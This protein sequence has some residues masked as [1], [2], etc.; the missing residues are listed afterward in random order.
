VGYGINVI[1]QSRRDGQG[2]FED[3]MVR[4]DRVELFAQAPSK[5]PEFVPA[6]FSNS[7]R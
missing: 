4:P 2:A 6:R 5:V 7:E 1:E 3:C